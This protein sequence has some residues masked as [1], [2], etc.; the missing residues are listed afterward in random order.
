MSPN[1][2]VAI[3]CS[4]YVGFEVRLYFSSGETIVSDALPLPLPF[5]RCS[6]QY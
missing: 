5:Y 3:R 2:G 6:L 4:N 1:G